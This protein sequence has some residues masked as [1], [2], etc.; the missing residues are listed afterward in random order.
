MPFL[1]LAGLT[2]IVHLAFIAFLVV[3]GFT[4]RRSA[5]MR[6]AHL[7]A[8]AITVAINLSGS[9][10]PLTVAE[11][12]L[13]EAGGAAPY[14]TGFVSHYLVEPFHPA[15]I[16]GTINLLILVAWMLPTATAYLWPERAR[17]T[18]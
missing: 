1:V 10:C 15:G 12:R 13:R 14:E 18:T 7:A 3:G 4:G 2:A 6:L 11:N 9:D 17:V 5:G 8:V 16:N